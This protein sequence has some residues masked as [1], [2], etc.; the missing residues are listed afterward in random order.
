MSQQWPL[1]KWSNKKEL[2]EKIHKNLLHCKPESALWSYFL[3]KCFLSHF[4]QSLW[5]S[6]DFILTCSCLK[7]HWK[8]TLNEFY[9]AL[10]SKRLAIVNGKFLDFI[11]HFLLRLRRKHSE[12]TENFQL[13]RYDGKSL[14]SLDFGD[15]KDSS[16]L[17][18]DFGHF[19]RVELGNKT[20]TDKISIDS[21]LRDH[22]MA[23]FPFNLDRKFLRVGRN[24]PWWGCY[25]TCLQMIA[26]MDGKSIGYWFQKLRIGFYEFSGPSCSLLSGLE[27]KYYR[28]V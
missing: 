20:A 16:F 14:S 26:S 6:D 13:I 9:F 19:E 28:S 11:F 25:I 18:A 4:E 1:L 5:V 7:Y 27:T 15:A 23:G 2:F 10:S 24:N 17:G 22:D 12:T 3:R 21:T 8:N